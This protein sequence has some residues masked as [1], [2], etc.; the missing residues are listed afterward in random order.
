[1]VVFENE[2]V[3]PGPILE[4]YYRRA[5]REWL[6]VYNGT[7]GAQFLGVLVYT[8]NKMALYAWNFADILIIFF[9]RALYFK[10]KRLNELA[11]ERLIDGEVVSS[12]KSRLKLTF[13][14]YTFNIVC[15]YT[16]SQRVETFDIRFHDAL[17]PLG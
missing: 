15:F 17:R 12:G 9:S 16:R 13:N 11:R 2:P 1:V 8:T 6:S 7:G 3:T 14:Y 5:Y 10:F 4:V